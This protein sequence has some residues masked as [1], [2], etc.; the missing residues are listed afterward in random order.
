MPAGELHAEMVETFAAFGFDLWS[1]GCVLA[2]RGRSVLAAM[3]SR[4]AQ[5]RSVILALLTAA[6]VIAKESANALFKR[7]H[8]ARG[9]PDLADQQRRCPGDLRAELRETWRRHNRQVS[10]VG[11]EDVDADLRER[12]RT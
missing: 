12:P 5:S 11:D 3:V 8:L 2:A 6:W 9:Y 7:A 1:R 4:T 10:K